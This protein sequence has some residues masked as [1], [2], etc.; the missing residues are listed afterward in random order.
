V[1]SV[2]QAVMAG[3][4]QAQSKFFHPTSPVIFSLH[5]SLLLVR[6]QVKHQHVEDSQATDH[7][8]KADEHE[9]S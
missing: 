1:F 9:A 6:Q 5:L 4:P 3:M 7:A 8:P 2:N